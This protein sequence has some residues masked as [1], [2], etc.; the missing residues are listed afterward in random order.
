[1]ITIYPNHWKK[2][3]WSSVCPISPSRP[4]SWFSYEVSATNVWWQGASTRLLHVGWFTVCTFRASGA[5]K[6][7]MSGIGNSNKSI[8]FHNSELTWNKLK[9]PLNPQRPNN[10]RTYVTKAFKALFTLGKCHVCMDVQ[11]ATD[12]VLDLKIHSFAIPKRNVLISALVV[13][14]HHH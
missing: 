6:G 7:D 10:H 1:M 9:P 12:K 13:S 14:C 8:V 11:S 2:K 3:H 5:S 4:T